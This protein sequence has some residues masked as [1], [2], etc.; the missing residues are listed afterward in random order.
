MGQTTPLSR[1]PYPNPFPNPNM[2]KW[3]PFSIRIWNS[4]GSLNAHNFLIFDSI[5]ALKVS[6]FSALHTDENNTKIGVKKCLTWP[7]IISL[8]EC[9]RQSYW[10]CVTAKFG[11]GRGYGW[12]RMRNRRGV[13]GYLTCC[14]V[15]SIYLLTLYWCF[16]IFSCTHCLP[17]WH[18]NAWCTQIIMSCTLW[19]IYCDLPHN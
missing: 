5:F 14:T 13:S 6:F 1:R 17:W 16:S 3:Y 15:F 11:C 4:V 7:N 19:F 8:N 18:Q 2:T 9:G 10:I 12:K